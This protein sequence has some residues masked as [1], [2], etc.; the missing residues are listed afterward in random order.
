MAQFNVDNAPSSS[1][2]T[3]LL[4][5]LPEPSR[6]GLPVGPRLVGGTSFAD[7]SA[8]DAAQVQILAQA[9]VAGIEAARQVIYGWQRKGHSLE[10]IY[11]RGILPCARLMGE[12]WSA[13]KLDFA[14]CSIGFVHLQK[15]L[16][17]FSAEFLQEAPQARNGWSLLL[18]SEPGSQHSMGLFMLSEFFK[19]AGWVVTL[20]VPQDVTEFKRLFHSDWFD[21]VGLSVSTDRHLDRLAALLPSLRKGSDNLGLH[22]FVGGP[23]ALFA[24]ESLQGLGIEVLTDDVRA[25]L[26]RIT[27]VMSGATVKVS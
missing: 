8:L 3:G 10:E 9:C 24:P 4:P 21:A 6:Q 18:L 20:G 15:L 7:K 12:W 22:V 26:V 25:T 11:L 2:E 23:M 16:Y 1:Q 27:Q 17:D 13:D 5:H 14:M 19:R